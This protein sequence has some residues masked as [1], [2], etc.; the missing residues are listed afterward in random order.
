MNDLMKYLDNLGDISCLLFNDIQKIYVPHGREWIKGKIYG[1][2]K[3][4]VK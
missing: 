4:L 2:L 3:K 1:S